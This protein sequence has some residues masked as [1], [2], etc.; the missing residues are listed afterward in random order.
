MQCSA[1]GAANPEKARF[2]GGCGANLAVP[3]SCPSCGAAIERDQRFCYECGGALGGTATAAPEPTAARKIVTIVFADLVGSTALHERLDAESA[4]RFMDAY[5]RA[6]R[7]AVEAHGGT[8]TQLLGDGV[9]AVF[10]APRVAEDDAIR[11]VRA[12]VAMQRSFRALADEQAGAVGAT[13]LRVAVNTGEVIASQGSEIIGDPVNVAARLQEEAGSGGVVIGEAT[14]RLVGELVTLAPLGAFA[15]KGRAEPV[16]AY[17][18]VSLERPAGASATPFVGRDAELR[19]LRAVYDAAVSE[20]RAK[21]AVILGSPGLGKSRVLGELVRRLEGGATVL[22]ARCDPGGGGTF[23]PLARGLRALLQQDDTAPAEAVQATLEKLLPDDAERGRIRDGIAALLAGTPAPPEETFFAVRRFLRALAGSRPIVLAIDDLHWAEP[24]LLD[25]CEHLVQWSTDVPMLV[26][27]AA[28]PELRDA[29]AALAAAGALVSDVVTL[30]GLDAGAATRLAANAIGAH[31]L[32]AA[33]AGRVLAASEGNPLFVS[34]LV[35]MLVQDGA[36][37]REGDHWRV[38]VE[39]AALEMPPTIHALLAARIERLSP[40]ERSVLERAAVVGRQF[41][42][43]AVKEL[44]PRDAP[45]LDRQLE[46]LR[47]SELIE[48][49]TGWFLGEPALRFHHALIRDAA[50]RRLLKNTRAELHARFADWV[51]GRVGESIEHDE[52]VGWHLEQAHQLLREL[53]PVDADG[54]AIG[55]RASKYLAAAGRRALARD[56]VPLAAGLLGRA[57][58]RLE[59]AD[60]ARA[61]LALD[62]CEALLAA[63]EVGTAE[64]AIDEL[65]RFMAGSPRLRAWHACFAGEHAALTDPKSLRSTADAVAAAAEQLTAAGDTA[66]EAKAHF[67]HAIALARLGK[68]GACEAALDRALAAARRARDRRR[69]N[70]VLS[71]A[72]LAA[73]WGPSPVTRASGRCLDVVRVLRI[74]QGSPAV[75]AVALRCQGVL[76][77]LRG[78]SEAARRMIASSRRMVEELGITHRLLQADQFAGQIELIEGDPVAA[79]RCLRTAYDGMKQLGLGSDAAQCAAQLGRALLAQDRA[80]EAE[81][82]SH[83]SEA[84]A[85]DDLQSA[86]AWRGVR[87]EALARRG[88]AEAAIEL[89]RAAVELASAT[90]A[91]LF[92]A[93]ARL[94]LAAALR[95]AGRHAEA[96]AEESRA[97][98]LWEAKGATLLAERARREGTPV[99]E[100]PAP[101]IRA[102]AVLPIRSRANAA[103]AALGRLEAA[104][105]ARDEVAIAAINSEDFEAIHHPTGAEWKLAGAAKSISAVWRTEGLDYRLEPL[106]TLGGSLALARQTVCGSGAPMGQSS[107]GPYEVEE[108]LVAGVDDRGRVSRLEYFKRDQLGDAIA[109]LYE[110]YAELLPDGPERERAAAIARFIAALEQF[111]RAGLAATLAPEVEYIDRRTLGVPTARGADAFVQGLRIRNDLAVG[112]TNRIEDILAMRDDSILTRQTHLGTIRASGG[113]YE[114]HSLSLLVFCANGR[115]AFWEAFDSDDHANA[116]AR[117]DE[118]TAVP[119]RPARRVRPNAAVPIAQRLDAAIVARDAEG[120]S[121]CLAED[122]ELID[123]STGTSYGREGMLATMQGLLLALELK[124]HSEPLATLGDLLALFRLSSSAS[125]L[126]ADSLDVGG[127][128][129]A[130]ITLG[131]ADAQERAK[132]SEMFAA[133]RLGDAMVRLYERYAELMP[134][135]S[136]RTRAAAIARSVAA[137]MGSYEAER[138]TPAIAPA[139]EFI[140]HRLLGLGSARGAERFLRGTRAVHEDAENVA[141]SVDDV[142]ALEPHAFLAL[143]TTSGTVRVGGG[144]WQRQFIGLSLFGPDGL[145]IQHELFDPD[146]RSEALARFDALTAKPV[147]QARRVRPNAATAYGARVN[148]AQLANATDALPALV[149]DDFSAIDHT[150]GTTYDRQGLLATWGSQLAARDP[151]QS[152]EDIAT[153]GDRLVLARFSFSASGF[154]GRMF[155]VGPY[156]RVSLHLTEVD[157]QGRG[158]CTEF[159]AVDHFGDAIVRMYERYAELLPAGPERDRAAGI[160]RSIAGVTGPYDPEGHARAFAPSIECVDHRVLGTVS[161]HGAEFVQHL[162]S[163]FAVSDDLTLRDDDILALQPDAVLVRRTFSGTGRE[164]GGLFE[165][166]LIALWVFGADGRIVRWE[167]FDTDAASAALARFD[168]LTAPPPIARPFEN[169]AT[170]DLERFAAAW[171]ARD[172]RGVEDCYAPG[173]RRFDRRKLILLDL[174]REQHLEWLR[175]T[176]GMAS[177]RIGITVLATRGERLALA[178]FLVAMTDRDVGATELEFLIVH[179]V[180]ES[181]VAVVMVAFGLDDLDAAYDELLTRYASQAAEHPLIASA[182]H[183]YARA[184][185][186]RDW[187]RLASLFASGFVMQDHRVLGMGTMRSGDEWVASQRS[188]IELRPDARMWL[189]HL[190]L[191]GRAAFMIGRWI[192]AEMDGNFEI[193]FVSAHA[194]GTDGRFDRWDIYDVDQLDAARA[195]FAELASPRDAIAAA[196]PARRRARVRP[197]AATANVD[198]LHAALSARD[199][200]AVRDVYAEGF[201]AIDHTT[202][203]HHDRDGIVAM[204]LMFLR[205][206][207]PRTMAESLA[208]LGNSLALQRTWTSASGFVGAKFD[209]GAFEKQ[210]L[211]LNEVDAQGRRTRHEVFAPDRVGDAVVRLYELHAE[212]LPEGPERARASAIARGVAAATGPLDFERVMAATAPEI[213]YVDR[214]MFGVGP[215]R[216]AQAFVRGA[217]IRLE[218]ASGVEIR[219]DDILDLRPDALLVRVTNA[220]TGASGDAYQSQGFA[221]YGFSVFGRIACWERFDADAEAAALARFDDLTGEGSRRRIHVRP[222]AATACMARLDV[223]IAARDADAVHDLLAERAEIQDHTTGAA[224]ERDGMIESWRAL[225]RSRDPV[226][227]TEPLATLGEALALCHL[228]ASASGFSGGT[229]DVGQYHHEEIDLIEVD[230]QGRCH[231][232]DLFGAGQLDQ[233]IAALY[234]RHAELLPEG[235]E[236]ARASAV[237]RSVPV[238]LGPPE[239]DVLGGVLAL[240]VQYADHRS[241]GWGVARGLVPFLQ[242]LRTLRNALGEI[243]VR[244][245]ELIA[246]R[247]DA[248]LVRRSLTGMPTGDGGPYRRHPIVLWAFSADGRVRHWEQFDGDQREKALARFDAVALPA[249]PVRLAE[250]AATRSADPNGQADVLATRGDRLALVRMRFEASDGSIAPDDIDYLSIIEV[251]RHGVRTD[252]VR[253]ELGDVDAAYAELDARY[254]A[255]EAQDHAAMWSALSGPR[256][257]LVAKDWDEMVRLFAPDLVAEDHRPLGFGVLHSPQEY[258]KAVRSVSDLRPDIRLRIDHLLLGPRAALILSNWTWSEGAETFGI[259]GL[260]VFAMVN[261]DRVDRVHHYGP[262]Q[263]ETARA[264]FAELAV[265]PAR[266]PLSALVEPNAASAAMDRIYALF[267]A[268]DWAGIRALCAPGMQDDD[269]RRQSLVVQDADGWVEDLRLGREPDGH[270]A[271]QLVG[272]AG[273]RLALERTVYSVGPPDGRSEIDSL[274]L[275]EVDERGRIAAIFAFDPDDWSGVFREAMGRLDPRIAAAIEPSFE[276]AEGF[277]A[278][279]RARMS[280]ALADDVHVNDRRRAGV[281]AIE[282]AEAYA[283]AIEALWQLSLDVRSQAFGVRIEPHG[284]LMAGLSSGI[285]LADG[286]FERLMITMC[287][288]T[289]ERITHLE[290][291]DL[292]DSDTALA[293]FEELRPDPLR[294]PPN[295]ASRAMERSYEALARD[296]TAA[297]RALAGPDFVYEDR[298]RRSLASGGVEPF[299]K[300]LQFYQ[301]QGGRPMRELIGTAGDRVSIVRVIWS[302]ASS[303]SEFEIELVVVVEV[304]AEGLQRSVIRFDPEDRPAAFAEA[305]ARFAAGEAAGVAAQAVIHALY[306]AFQ[307]NDRDGATR[308]LADDAVYQ[309]RRTPSILGTLDRDQWIESIWAL[310]ELAPDVDSEIVRI[311]RWNER[312]RVHRLRQFGTRDGGPF[313]TA[314]L[315]VIRTN[316]DRITCYEAFNVDA[317]DDA[318]ARFAELCA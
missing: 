236:R 246:L 104:I 144:V 146:D 131:E 197:N 220:G 188:L 222:N 137:L 311:L 55:E 215:A 241:L 10:G 99:V 186:T 281:G 15:V 249:Q 141:I 73:L 67:V 228:T 307:R 58:A 309:D 308:C 239:P 310:A 119:A 47:R 11:A 3:Q 196:L 181:G 231:R 129:T 79:E 291:F 189:E 125:G 5:Y 257:A 260:L 88:D 229:L 179:E 245:A 290:L 44:L 102:E 135:G 165:R 65:A 295:T 176:F 17:R 252:Q 8:V 300:T 63:G 205:A 157:A 207:D 227:E 254:A 275:T 19:R 153:L 134:E 259:P 34:E 242:A 152:R 87:A 168:E 262:E 32:P 22:S 223:A 6:M 203:S 130:H 268:R 159:F 185:A 314:S 274:L 302:G 317:L 194:V 61:E 296:D 163:W 171:N 283:D 187:D 115:L 9:K 184:L 193:P 248:L 64:R 150:T 30:A 289:D 82:L 173:F 226:H 24:L 86:I 315:L 267:E 230:A 41:S 57:L 37:V 318:L 27:V 1:C 158:L 265:P 294:I 109:R 56:D 170:R 45:D 198:R 40:D 39:L 120:Y 7:G 297:L 280:A 303:A 263:L 224:F 209:V 101:T 54:R 172:W 305:H 121:A 149:A 285:G 221:L 31:E 287:V 201:E 235:P 113:A 151:A 26:V 133:D 12:A 138:W 154:V 76:E 139:I 33:V 25:L 244:V 117:F 216:G 240:D 112:V 180:D 20:Q 78:R 75:E 174:D 124:C 72:P 123:H 62:W 271:R 233:A 103:T 234:Q 29:R 286:P 284:V 276:F 258:M 49:D 183:H 142:L 16:T 18:V 92:H 85:G 96:A 218:I 301:S 167:I 199:A 108:L 14:R 84:L 126:V 23:A 161:G 177:R 306:S 200:G 70:A 145:V 100:R 313:E 269:R 127:Y 278:H 97:V 312:G 122:F 256:D 299:I 110:R 35:R 118:L 42:R 28:R 50:Y 105:N 77:A 160:A 195:R 247:A 264:R 298:G 107:V 232:A 93:E 182:Q 273:D 304:D 166:H 90:D 261:S 91:L 98:E 46:A 116:L 111:D 211:Y 219:I 80:A 208:T 164:S 282:G 277:N 156:E 169:A 132:R 213:E 51:I 288:A 191:N 217:R 83:E 155:D 21:L 147:R 255:G 53:G 190:T 106:A 192:G 74:T 250:N 237:A 178:K 279:D 210:E 13:G 175:M 94:A 52:T 202:G 2:C 68:V 272:T 66:G 36:L 251:D 243:E 48:P 114:S 60:S 212:L 148:E 204:N 140:D 292:E 59:P 293:R 253:F 214:R 69:S 136:E 316:G 266:D 225:L 143:R 81:A 238:V 206:R 128:E 270:F 4:G 71:G 43:A 95:A 162:R 89:A 38:G